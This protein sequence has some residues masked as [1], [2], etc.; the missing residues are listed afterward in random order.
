M[1]DM[2]L[3]SDPAR[4][5]VRE[6]FGREGELELLRGLIDDARNGTSGATLL[7]G[8]AGVGKTAL[9]ERLVAHASGLRL[10]RVVGVESEMQLGYAALH[11]LLLP[12]MEL[13]ERLP[14]PQQS[15]VH[16]AFGMSRI[17][18]PDAFMLGLA[19][20][21]ILASASEDNITLCT[22][23]DAQWLDEE[24]LS[25]LA[26]VARRA[27]GV[28]IVLV[29]AARDEGTV[30]SELASIRVCEVD[31]LCEE[32][33][34][35]LLVAAVHHRVEEGVATRIVA[36][37]GGNPLALIELGHGLQPGQLDGG[38]LLPEPLPLSR[39]VEAR[40]LRQVHQLSE[41]AQD[42]GPDSCG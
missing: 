5:T 1:H 34:R 10:L 14:A 19:C 35:K 17:E 32:A 3:H 18:K 37:T 26:F 12:L 21:T 24:S 11:Q 8:E 13:V 25:V 4:P 7:I 31:G 15:A 9:I 27:R 40:F 2:H 29:F 33:A 16:A 22:I 30:R 39:R 6:L 41:P 38:A 42:R 36:S 23:D 20:L 28:P